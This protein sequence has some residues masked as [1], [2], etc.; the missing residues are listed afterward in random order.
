MNS[1]ASNPVLGGERLTI[2]HLNYDTTWREFEATVISELISF[3]TVNTEFKKRSKK[4]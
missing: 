1:P 3:L 4:D 2:N